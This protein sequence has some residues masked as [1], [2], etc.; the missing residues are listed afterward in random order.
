MRRVIVSVSTLTVMVVLGQAAFRSVFADTPKGTDSQ[1]KT[2]TTNAKQ[3][4]D[5]S[6]N[7]EWTLPNSAWMVP[8]AEEIPILYVPYSKTKE[9]TALP[10]FWNPGT[11]RARD[12]KTGE[13]VD[14]KVVRIKLPLGLNQPP[15]V[16]AEN[17]MIVGRWALG[18][19]LFF[20]R[21]LSSD[22]SVSCASCHDPKRG[23]TDQ[24][25]FATG[26][27]G[28]LGGMSAPTI[29]N[30][31]YHQLQFW[32]GRAHSLEDQA[33]GPVANAVEMFD[34]KG[35]AW[36]SVVTRVRQKK[37]YTPRFHKFFGVDPT[38]DAIAKAIA[39]Y[40]RTVFSGNSITDR[41][42]LAMRIRAAD[43]ESTKQ[44]VLPKD[45]EG[46][47]K[48]AIAKKDEHSLSALKLTGSEDAAKI[49]N[50]ATSLSRGRA[51]FFGKA[52]CN[53]CHVGDNFT[54]N[55]FHNIGV[56]VKN[57][58][59]TPSLL[60][61]YAQLPLGH[62]DPQLVGA[63]KTPTVRGLVGTSPFLHDGS[64]DTLE[65]VVDF[66]DR[67]GEPSEY[68]DVKMRNLDAE[69]SFELARAKKTQYT[70]PE[71]KVIN[72]KAIAPLKLNLTS[73]E[74]QDLVAFMRSLQGDAVDPIVSD[75]D[76][77]PETAAK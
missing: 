67:G 50:L 53:S 9:W 3:A 44:D 59:I 48:E 76:R 17:P 51:L 43:E 35:N 25:R 12:P 23:F 30:S 46:V 58:V 37:D 22:A 56:G 1:F 69:V 47:L 28:Q 4:E 64:E 2:G 66:Y 74:K 60:G 31:A 42:E 20:D 45:Y 6:K 7:L 13:E 65:K 72:G 21:A 14:R 26:I 41:A 32:D 29:L 18:K 5:A 34:G 15:T 10:S 27:G 8:F 39:T 40:E 71:V 52:R 73:Q 36:D 68:L 19:Q 77:T 24:S 33:Q 16:P 11:E 54:D 62:K 38:R 57:G 61:R 63:F 75:R 55:Q 70:G 49:R